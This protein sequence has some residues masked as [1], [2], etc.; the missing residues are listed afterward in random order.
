M[1]L[2]EPNWTYM[3]PL[4]KMHQIFNVPGRGVAILPE[5]GLPHSLLY[6]IVVGTAFP[7]YEEK[8]VSDRHL[9]SCPVRVIKLHVSNSTRSYPITFKRQHCSGASNKP[10][11]LKAGLNAI[12]CTECVSAE[13]PHQLHWGDWEM[14]TAPTWTE[15]TF[16]QCV[17]VLEQCVH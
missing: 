17:Y 4:A 14:R 9:C 1:V 7:L 3:D 6:T 10:H 5:L 8:E 2:T 16:S 15:T 13:T 12:R 11:H